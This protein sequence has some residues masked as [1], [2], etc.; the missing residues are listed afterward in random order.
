MRTRGLPITE[1]QIQVASPSQAVDLVALCEGETR[2]RELVDHLHSGIVVYEAMA[3]GED[4]I[5][6]DFN[7]TAAW[8]EKTTPQAVIGRPVTEAF[9]GVRK[10]GLLDVLRRVSKTGRAEHHP[11][12]LYQDDRLSSWRENYVYRLPSGLVV[13]V[14]DDVTERKRAEDAL[15]ESEERYRALFD[16]SLDCVYLHDFEGRFLD[17]NKA[18]AALLGYTRKEIRSLTFASLLDEAEL[19]QAAAALQELL[20]TGQQQGKT[21]YRLR[22]KDGRLVDV[23]LQ[24]SVVFRG[25]KPYAVQGIARD[26]TERKRAEEALRASKQRLDQLAEQS[27]AVAWEVD[28]EGLYTYVSHVV[29]QVFGYQPDELV[30]KRHFYD[31]HPEDGR[32]AFKAAAFEVFARKEPF[33]GLENVVS[34]KEGRVVWVSTNGLPL[35]D[36][37]GVLLGY[38]GSD[39]D[40]TE[41][42]RA[43]AALL[44]SEERYRS[45]VDNAP[46]GVFV[47]DEQGHY[48]E[49]NRAAAELTGYSQEEL[50]HLSIVDVVAPES[51]DWGQQHFARLLKSG[52]SSGSGLFLRKDGTTL[53]V[54]VDAVR[55]SATRYLDFIVDVS[56]Q[57]RA[58]A[59]LK[60]GARQLKLTL[61]AAVAA[62]G[63]T[64]ELRD[65][66]TAGHQ[67]R[68]AELADAIAAELGWEEKR[69]ETLNTAA[70]LHDIGKIVV[71][72]EILAKPGRLSEIEMALIRQHAGAGADT[73]ADIDFEGDIAEMIRQHHERLDGSGYPAGL[74]DGEI[75]P[76][77]RVLAVADVVEA[78]ISHRP[79]RPALPVEEALTEIESG[80]GSRY[81]ADACAACVRLFREQG[82]TLAA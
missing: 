31:L 62:L 19:S 51:R 55:L 30:G 80:A 12:A 45:Y 74:R 69:I 33:V 10:F 34:A 79:Y 2:Y 56:E 27:R 63:T 60:A 48:L 17:A 21:E 16:R 41:R 43:E 23:E 46:Y 38:R 73:V 81:D 72:A 20:A 77:A 7:P 47:A 26:I 15:R 13:A 50:T 65:P 8:L 53:H 36:A 58:K 70:L 59:E 42:K 39:T 24:A 3:G 75:L 22:H 40:I 61:A 68:V 37:N 76:E 9:P 35:L 5:I 82:F 4:F 78:M 18:A 49:V 6:R 67:R 64:T 57:E 14:Y 11:I 29:E 32:A 44:E 71:P 66:Y 28:A 52:G 1:E 54:R 25:K